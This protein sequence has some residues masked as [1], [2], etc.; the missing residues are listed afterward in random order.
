MGKFKFPSLYT[1]QIY[2]LPFLLLL[3]AATFPLK[4]YYKN[5]NKLCQCVANRQLLLL[6]Y[7][8]FALYNFLIEADNI[9]RINK[10]DAMKKKD[11]KFQS[12]PE[13]CPVDECKKK[14]KMICSVLISTK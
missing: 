12:T 5:T 4:N 2:F 11:E 14:F 1:T 8:F 6:Y 13:N 10:V 7:L 3:S 9:K